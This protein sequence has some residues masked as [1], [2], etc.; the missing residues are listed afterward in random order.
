ML[1][2]LLG[3]A[4]FLGTVGLVFLSLGAIVYGVAARRPGF[5]RFVALGTVG[6]LGLYGLLVAVSPL[7]FPPRVLA[8]GQER[9]YC[10]LDCHLHLAV[11][12]VRVD[13]PASGA[14]TRLWHLRLRVRSNAAREPEYPSALALQVVDERG[15][16]HELLPAAERGLGRGPLARALGPGEAYE[17]ELAIALPR[18][19]RA[20]RLVAY[21]R[22][23]PGWLVP[24]G[25]NTRVQRRISQRLAPG[26][27]TPTPAARAP[28][29]VAGAAPRPE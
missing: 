17:T 15:G 11:A 21:W 19:V 7:V 10:G 24:F 3:L 2:R 16:T 18:E 4:L 12:G 27:A 22:G 5:A 6:W 23:L 1:I 20:P 29:P 25:E 14:D 28:E 8:P 13:P 9:V 26:P